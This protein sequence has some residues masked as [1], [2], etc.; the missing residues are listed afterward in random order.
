MKQKGGGDQVLRPLDQSEA[1]PHIGVKCPPAILIVDD[2]PTNLR[3]MHRILA[4]QWDVEI[5]SDAEQAAQML[6]TRGFHSV[7]TDYDMPGKD[8]IWLLAFVST[9]YPHARR[10]LVSGGNTTDIVPHIRSG[11]V[12][13][14]LSKPIRR[15]ELR[16]VVGTP[17]PSGTPSPQP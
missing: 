16:V 11:L 1:I 5:A 3:L 14:F 17:G 2:D 8:G 10:I 4:K 15:D 7:I 9:H 13:G 6:V 12:Q